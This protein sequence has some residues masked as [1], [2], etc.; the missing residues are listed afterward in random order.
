MIALH[1]YSGGNGEYEIFLILGVAKNQEICQNP[2]HSGLQSF[3][4]TLIMLTQMKSPTDSN[5]TYFQFKYGKGRGALRFCQ[6]APVLFPLLTLS[7]VFENFKSYLF[8]SQLKYIYSFH[9]SEPSSF[10]SARYISTGKCL[11][12]ARS[13]L[14]FHH[15][16]SEFHLCHPI[17][18]CSQVSF[19]CVLTVS[20]CFSWSL[21]YKPNSLK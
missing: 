9:S 13:F 21:F 17:T 6:I 16:T 2:D 8:Y 10:L 19:L 1:D 20:I 14:S 15:K 12:I 5:V 4:L 7:S 11:N 18:L 3:N